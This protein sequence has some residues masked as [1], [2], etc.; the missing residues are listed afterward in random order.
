MV[1]RLPHLRSG[2][3]QGQY[4]LWALSTDK[5]TL[6]Y[7]TECSNHHTSLSNL[8][9]KEL[10]YSKMKW[11]TIYTNISVN[12]IVRLPHP[13]SRDRQAQKTFLAPSAEKQTNNYGRGF[14][15]HHPSLS[16]LR[17]MWLSLSKMKWCVVYTNLPINAIVTL[18]HPRSRNSQGQETFL[19]PSE[20]R[21]TC[22]SER[23]CSN[24]HCSPSILRLNGLSWSKTKWWAMYTNL[25]V[26][27]IVRLSHPWSW[28][29]QDRRTFFELST[30]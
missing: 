22:N 23:E 30:V 6:K 2:D 12:A 29:S 11:W 14:S 15:N 7:D 18:P 17:S 28:D 5:L 4:K 19:A 25:P 20:Y 24:Y 13:Q 21:Q 8:R 3:S 1:V 16:T 26:I 10:R 9:L 27:T